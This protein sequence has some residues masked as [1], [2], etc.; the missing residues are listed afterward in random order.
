M[1]ALDGAPRAHAAGHDPVVA[2]RRTDCER[3]WWSRQPAG[4]DEAERSDW[5]MTRVYASRVE[6]DGSVIRVPPGRSAREPEQIGPVLIA[7][8]LSGYRVVADSLGVIA[9]PA[10]ESAL[11]RLAHAWALQN[12]RLLTGELPHPTARIV[13]HRDLRERIDAVTPY[14]L[15]GTGISPI[16][17]ADSLYW[18]IDLYSASNSYPLSE[19]DSTGGQQRHLSAARGHW[20]DE[21]AHGRHVDRHGFG[22]GSDCGELARGVSVL[23][24]LAIRAPARKS[25]ARCLRRWTARACRDAS[26][27]A[28]GCAARSSAMGICSRRRPAPTPC[29]PARA[30]CSL[31]PGPMRRSGARPCWIPMSTQ[32]ACCS[33]RAAPTRPCTGFRSGT[34]ARAG[35]PIADQL[36]RA[37]D[38]TV[39]APRD[40]SAVHGRVRMVPLE[41]GQLLFVQPLYA[42]R[43]DGAT[44]LGV[45]ATTDTVV[46]A[47]RTLTDAL[48]ARA[49]TDRIHGADRVRGFPRGRRAAVRTHVGCDAA[50][51]LGRLRP[52]VRRAWRAPQSSKETTM[53][54][55]ETAVIALGGNALS[56]AGEHCTIA[57]AVRAH[58]REPRR[59]C[60]SRARRLGSLPRARQWSAGRR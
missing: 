39:S 40:A 59:H 1:R 54:D 44:L 21:R 49:S 14:F 29:S 9:A 17:V 23:F 26:S 7:D 55:S 50:R 58:A 34:R 57:R 45:A 37:L 30:R 3:P 31:F 53:N 22:E 24:A 46:T 13:T 33:H 32:L 19:R 15:Q 16:V 36:R 2:V 38:T 20:R 60:R 27:R 12:F 10:L 18:A 4:E 8:S 41:G 51:R 28:S 5:S 52:R 56:P 42:W 11:S 6:S 35:A 47:A 43:T 48:G 25:R